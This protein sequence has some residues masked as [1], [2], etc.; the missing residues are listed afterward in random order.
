[1]ICPIIKIGPK[2]VR[3]GR[4]PRRRAYKELIGYYT[5]THKMP[6]L[7]K[8]HWVSIQVIIYYQQMQT[9]LSITQM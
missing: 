4:A 7:K 3:A 2:T 1:M 6:L 9:F 8:A 5:H